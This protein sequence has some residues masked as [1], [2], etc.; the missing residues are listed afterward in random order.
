MIRNTF[1]FLDGIGEKLEKRLWKNRIL[2]WND[3]L[4]TSGFDFINPA[5]KS[6]FDKNLLSSVSA[7]KNF[8]TGYFASSVKRKEHWRLYEIFKSDAVCLDIETS[9]LMPNQ[10]GEVTVVG[11]Y[12]GY[13]YKCLINGRDLTLDNLQK[14][15]SDYKYLITFY[16]S[17]FDVPFLIKTMPGLKFNIPH[18]DLCFGARRLKFE[19]GL[20]KLEAEFGICR[21]ES[22]VGMSGYDAVVLWEHAKTGSSEALD[23]LIEYNREDTVNLFRIADVI[24]SGLRNQTGI[25]EFLN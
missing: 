13:D 18:F 2:T 21:N 9:G 3:F 5:K 23:L 19:G 12:N 11:L 6:I 14:E 16:G 15:L 25:D 8:D 17:A 20:K 7:L 24:Y 10:G 4:E 22:V 1:N